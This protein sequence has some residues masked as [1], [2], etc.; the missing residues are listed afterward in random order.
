MEKTIKRITNIIILALTAIAVIAAVMIPFTA[1][2]TPEEVSASREMSLNIGAVGMY[3]LAITA[4][5]LIVVFAL[6]QVASNG[7]QLVSTLVLLAIVAVI[8]LISYFAASAEL[9]EVA[10]KIGIGEGLYKWIGAGVN[11]AYIAFMGVILAWIGSFV[12]VKI[13]K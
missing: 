10:M 6:F 1:A 4:L 11:V 12:Y 13:K 2:S 7:K 8:V 3:V 9:S 5:I